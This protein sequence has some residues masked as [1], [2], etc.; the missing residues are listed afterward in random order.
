MSYSDIKITQADINENNVRSASDILIG[1]AD[2]NKAVFDKLPEFI[3][4]K[5]NELVDALA[6]L[7]Q[8]DTEAIEKI[9]KEKLNSPMNGLE[10]NPG[11]NGD[12]LTAEGDGRTKWTDRNELVSPWLDV[13]G[14]ELID[15]WLDEHPEATTTVQD[16]SLT[17]PKFSDSLKLKTIKDYVTPEMFGAKGDGLTDDTQAVQDAVDFAFNNNKVVYL[18]GKYVLTDSLKVKGVSVTAQNIGSELV[19]NGYAHLIAGTTLTNIIETSPESDIRTYGIKIK[20][21]IIDGNNVV[22]NGFYSG[23]STSECIFENITINQCTN[24]LHINGNCYLNNFRAVRPYHCTTY[25]ILLEGGN[26]TSNVFEKCYVDTCANAYKINGQYST[27]ISCCADNITGIVYDLNSFTGALI[28]C[29]SEATAFTTMF[30]AYTNSDVF[31]AGGMYFGNPN[32]AG[33]YFDV[34]TGCFVGAYNCIFNYNS[35][36]SSGSLCRIGHAGKLSLKDCSKYRGFTGENLLESSS[37]RLFDGT[38]IKTLDVSVTLNEN[39]EAVISGLNPLRYTILEVY[40]TDRSGWKMIP[41][42]TGTSEQVIH[43]M[44][45]GNW[46]PSISDKNFTLRITYIDR[47]LI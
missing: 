1:N 27:M 29:G 26:N 21:I 31:I 19:G 46:A 6:E 42:R 40:S 39:N 14:E 16:G 41:L 34:D 24:G 12:V 5:H 28:G 47:D 32:L 23:Y 8:G 20:N 9:L 22:T 35:A 30:R 15:S 11:N 10:P 44:T 2:D 7:E 25:G 38:A 43:V 3:A 4:G 45:S 37:A 17:E 36:A 13:H 33:Y 18:T